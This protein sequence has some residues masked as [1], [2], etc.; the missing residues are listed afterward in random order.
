MF[1]KLKSV[2]SQNFKI[3][4]QHIVFFFVI[5][6][7]R[8]VDENYKLWKKCLVTVISIIQI[9][10]ITFV[11]HIEKLFYVSSSAGIWYI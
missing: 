10:L 1:L 5:I 4:F 7:V 11:G 2:L 9:S 3:P 8:N 6:F